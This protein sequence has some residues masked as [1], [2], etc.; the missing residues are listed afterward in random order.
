MCCGRAVG[1]V[2]PTYSEQVQLKCGIQYRGHFRQNGNSAG[3]HTS[4]G[5]SDTSK[6]T[7]AGVNCT[8]SLAIVTENYAHHSSLFPLLVLA[9]VLVLVL[10]LVLIIARVL[11]LVLV[12]VL[13]LVLV[14]GRELGQ[15]KREYSYWQGLRR[16]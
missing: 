5:T 3:M 4:I 16:L 15:D 9:L 11:V 13:V 14:L 10:V 7:S 8:T 1:R 12:R 2:V 6:C